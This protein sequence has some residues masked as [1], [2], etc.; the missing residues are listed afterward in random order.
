M[1]KK[2]QIACQTTSPHKRSRCICLTCGQTAQTEKTFSANCWQLVTALWLTVALRSITKWMGWMPPYDLILKN[3]VWKFYWSEYHFGLNA[4]GGLGIQNTS[5]QDNCAH[6]SFHIINTG[7][8][9][10]PQNNPTKRSSLEPCSLDS[11]FIPKLF[12]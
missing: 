7:R 9:Q 12:I 10:P 8:D 1:Q 5:C 3:S 2:E 11:R 6:Q 4:F